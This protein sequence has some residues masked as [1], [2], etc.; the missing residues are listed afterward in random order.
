[1]K[2]THIGVFFSARQIIEGDDERFGSNA[3][4]RLSH[5]TDEGSLW[6]N[7]DSQ[8]PALEMVD[9]GY[10][11]ENPIASSEPGLVKLSSKDPQLSMNTLQMLGFSTEGG[12]VNVYG[13]KI[14]LEAG[15]NNFHLGIHFETLGQKMAWCKNHGIEVKEPKVPTVAEYGGLILEMTHGLQWRDTHGQQIQPTGRQRH[16]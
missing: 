2:V 8:K 7:C 4:Y 9:K 14:M 1:M 12:E 13:L 15:P 5:P 3:G 6:A 16:R 10:M 11:R